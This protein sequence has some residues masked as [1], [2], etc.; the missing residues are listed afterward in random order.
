MNWT[1]FKPYDD[2]YWA[3]RAPVD[4]DIHLSQTTVNSMD[5]CPAKQGYRDVEGY[6]HTPSLAM[7]FG[8]MGH[9]AIEL[10]LVEGELHRWTADD[11]LTLW[12]GGLW[13]ERDGSW[14][15]HEL[16]SP[17]QLEIQLAE[18]VDMMKKWQ[19]HVY[20][21]L[22]LSSEA[23]IEERATK[24]LGMLDDGRVAWFGG[25]ADV[26]DP[27]AELILDWK[28]AGRGWDDSKA[29]TAGQASA[30][31]WL[32][33]INSHLYWVWNRQK[34]TWKS[35]ATERTTAQVDSYLRHSWQRAL[36]IGAGVYPATPWQTTFGKTKRAWYCSALYCGAWDVCEM[37]NLSDDV[38]EEQAIDVKA[39]WK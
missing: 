20:P 21:T 38:W 33:G 13:Y 27:T 30:Y 16:I 15:L 12:E 1:G 14:D 8:T 10:D 24:P 28:T 22:N 7:S 32:Y 36:Q 5:F 6:N 31:T 26:A 39:S 34:K 17:A 4:G 2:N 29:R 35:H 37:K 18:A 25:T 19:R 23:L 3:G 11:L 9:G